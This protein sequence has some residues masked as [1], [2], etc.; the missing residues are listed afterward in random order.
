MLSTRR[1][2]WSMVGWQWDRLP[3]LCA[4]TWLSLPGFR[5]FA[6]STF[7]WLGG[8]A[9]RRFARRP[10]LRYSRANPTLPK[11]P[12][13]CPGLL[14]FWSIRRRM[15]HSAGVDLVQQTE[16]RGDCGRGSRIT[17]LLPGS[18]RPLACRRC[19]R[20]ARPRA[21]R[22][23]ERGRSQKRDGSRR[24]CAQHPRSRSMILVSSRSHASAT[25]RFTVPGAAPVAWQPRSAT[26]SRSS[27]VACPTTGP[28][29][30]LWA[31]AGLS[32]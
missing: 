21:W 5:R 29:I 18:F 4:L 14:R 12:E 13:T 24:A 9:V 19:L 25:L 16:S 15:V 27:G 2:R 30:A 31:R 28:P 8:P 1:S 32:L 23:P 11:L 7:P 17:A 22:C 20:W 6:L 10:Q 26:Q 3:S